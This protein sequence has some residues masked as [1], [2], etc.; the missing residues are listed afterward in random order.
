MD[1]LYT[2]NIINDTSENFENSNWLYIYIYNVLK[3]IKI[4]ELTQLIKIYIYI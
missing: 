1:T 3:W 2:L 4:C